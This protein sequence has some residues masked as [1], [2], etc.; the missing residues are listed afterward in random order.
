MQ[1][2][3]VDYKMCLCLFEMRIHLKCHSV[4]YV[5]NIS[6]IENLAAPHVYVLYSFAFNS[7][8][9]VCCLAIGIT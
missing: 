4:F 1:S 8:W 7:S 9:C 6:N 2:S 5:K 3:Y